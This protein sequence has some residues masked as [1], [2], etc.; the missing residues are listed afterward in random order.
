MRGLFEGGSFMRKYGS[1]YIKKKLKENVNT[2]FKMVLP[3]G[4]QDQT[5]A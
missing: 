5:V 1:L 3:H 4:A 2:N